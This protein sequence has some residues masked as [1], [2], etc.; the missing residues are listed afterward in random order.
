V[1]GQLA[2]AIEHS[3]NA[4]TARLDTSPDVEAARA[5]WLQTYSAAKGVVECVFRL[6][7][8]MHLM[9][10]VFHDLAVPANAKV[11]SIPE[12]TLSDEDRKPA[13]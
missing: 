1:S 8:K 3:H 6:T 13:D 11:T 2:P 12:P 10:A 9:S 4:K 5:S 7:G